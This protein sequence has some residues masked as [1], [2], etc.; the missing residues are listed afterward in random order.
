MSKENQVNKDLVKGNPSFFN[1]QLA[2]ISHKQSTAISK[3][4]KWYDEVLKLPKGTNVY[5]A[6]KLLGIPYTSL[7]QFLRGLEFNKLIS[8]EIK[9]QKG[10]AVKII[11][12]RSEESST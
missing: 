5:Q 1:K 9:I 10:R 7:N 11:I 4:Q 6:S 3:H 2:E 8:T 12:P